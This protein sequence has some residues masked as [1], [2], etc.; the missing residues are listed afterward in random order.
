MGAFEQYDSYSC[1][2]KERFPHITYVSNLRRVFRVR[3]REIT[4]PIF[5]MT[6]I[7]ANS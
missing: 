2:L 4:I 5:V 1:L 3:V 7:D 6:E